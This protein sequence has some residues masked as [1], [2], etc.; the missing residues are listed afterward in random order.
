MLDL[1]QLQLLAQLTDN[2]E[3]SIE[4]LEKAYAKNNSKE[5]KEIK[6]EILNIQNKVEKITRWV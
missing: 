4:K 6:Q 3:I 2:L 1:D 5:F